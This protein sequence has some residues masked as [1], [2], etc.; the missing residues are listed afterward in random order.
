M[1]RYPLSYNPILDYYGKIERKEVAVSKA[2]KQTYRHL[3]EKIENP[4]TYHYSAARANHILEF[5]ENY[6]RLSQGKKGF[7]PLVS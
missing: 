1:K 5:A 2:I 6:C 7:Q 3:V 4:G